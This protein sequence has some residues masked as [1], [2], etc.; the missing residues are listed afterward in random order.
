MGAAEI[1]TILAMSIGALAVGAP[2]FYLLYYFEKTGTWKGL[3]STQKNRRALAIASSIS[4][5]AGMVGG[6]ALSVGQEESFN[7]LWILVPVTMSMGIYFLMVSL[8]YK[9]KST[10]SHK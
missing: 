10:T 3:V 8:F 1:I 2:I 7:S 9:P 5:I 6:I 4:L